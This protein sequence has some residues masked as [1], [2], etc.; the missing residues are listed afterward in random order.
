M[1]A[2]KGAI[3]AGRRE[4]R[5]WLRNGRRQHYPYRRIQVWLPYGNQTIYCAKEVLFIIIELQT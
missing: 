3:S 5:V 4:P 2:K 1:A